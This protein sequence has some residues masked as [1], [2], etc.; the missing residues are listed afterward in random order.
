MPALAPGRRDDVASSS[1]P[2]RGLSLGALVG[3]LVV[4]AGIAVGMRTMSDNSFLTHLATGRLILDRGSVP[5]TDPYTFSAAGEPWVVQ[6]WLM[7]VAYATAEALGGLDGIRLL[8]G[9]IAGALLA[10]AWRLLRPID[11]LVVRLAVAGL[12]IAVG[13]GLWAERPLMVG[14]LGFG[15]YALAAERGLDPRWLVPVG[16][17][18]VNSHGSFPLGLAYLLLLALGARLD[19]DDPAHELRCAA[20][21]LGGLLLG[22][23][24]PLGPKVL[25]FP[26]ELLGRQELLSNVIEW[27]APTF[28]STSQRAFIAQLALAVVLIARRPKYRSALVVGAFGA[29]ALLGARNLTVASLAMLPAI[30]PALVGIGGLRS[31]ARVGARSPLLLAAAA[32]PLLVVLIRLDAPALDLGR[33]PIDALAYIEEEGVDLED[34]RLMAPD[35]VGNVVELVYGPGRRVHFDDRFDLFPDDVADDYLD[36]FNARPRMRSVLVEEEIHLGLWPRAGA[37]A[38]LLVA[39]ADWRQLYSDEAWSLVCRRGV[40][41]SPGLTC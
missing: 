13:A 7:S 21:A 24:G 2:R 1:D 34:H 19:G 3:L 25:L 18:W 35:Y 9:A 11:G 14:L 17:L 8:G 12:F 6:S 36:V 10:V 20:W 33:Y 39:D 22:V 23:I 37:V 4:A 27:R 26:V 5:S 16:W 32:M 30:A 40:R 15:L 28:E 31:A 38:R 41:L 29:A